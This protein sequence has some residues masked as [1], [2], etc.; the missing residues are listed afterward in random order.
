MSEN[1]K[2]LDTIKEF[3]TEN[4]NNDSP[5]V[6]NYSYRK[7]IMNALIDFLKIIMNLFMKALFSS[8]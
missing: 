6:F 1:R 3:F 2:I 5:H 8:G 4:D 7:E